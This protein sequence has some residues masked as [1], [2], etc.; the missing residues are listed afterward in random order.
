[1]IPE[2]F[3]TWCPA[4]RRV[5]WDLW[6]LVTP[7]SLVP[8]RIAQVRSGPDY[9]HVDG[10]AVDEVWTLHDGTVH[11]V[12]ELHV[13]A[14]DAVIATGRRAADEL[15]GFRCPPAPDVDALRWA[16]R[17]CS[18]VAAPEMLTEYSKR[19]R[20]MVLETW[21]EIAELERAV[22]EAR[23]VRLPN[24]GSS[25]RWAGALELARQWGY[26]GVWYDGE[27]HER[28]GEIAALVRLP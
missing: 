26:S 15:R 10:H 21:E 5:L 28:A 23:A 1:M 17:L 24:L 8:P 12:A 6:V 11:H 25:L 9:T 14:M 16:A 13:V 27:P 19:S 2:A 18:E 22:L 7:R 4:D 3:V 20:G